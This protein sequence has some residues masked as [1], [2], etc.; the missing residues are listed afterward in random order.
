MLYLI[1]TEYNSNVN[2]KTESV[3]TFELDFSGS[4]G[5]HSI[6]YVRIIDN[7][8]LLDRVDLYS[9]QKYQAV[10]LFLSAVIQQDINF[11]MFDFHPDAF[12]DF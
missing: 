2:V 1:L 7:V 4:I 8:W 11:I 5:V 6:L 3:V 10:S 9:R 12:I